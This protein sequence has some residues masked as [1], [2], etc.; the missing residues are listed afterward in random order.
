MTLDALAC[1]TDLFAA[2][3]EAV[4]SAKAGAAEEMIGDPVAVS[5][6]VTLLAQDLLAALRGR[7]G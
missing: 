1:L 2:G 7:H 4:G 6:S 3:P 5:E